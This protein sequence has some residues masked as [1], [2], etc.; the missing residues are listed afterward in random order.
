MQQDEQNEQNEQN[1][2]NA[3]VKVG[4]DLLSKLINSIK[5]EAEIAREAIRGGPVNH[6]ANRAIEAAE[7]AEAEAEAKAAAN[8][9][10]QS[11]VFHRFM[12][13]LLK[14]LLKHQNA[15]MKIPDQKGSDMINDILQIINKYKE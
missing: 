11:I 3:I 4:G 15:L 12:N 6:A 9:L 5:T 2:L 1:K 13:D 14:V 10:R 8:P 7:K